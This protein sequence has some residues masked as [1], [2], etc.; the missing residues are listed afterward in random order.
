MLKEESFLG[1]Q[2]RFC[3]ASSTCTV[4]GLAGKASGKNKHFSVSH[5]SSKKIWCFCPSIPTLFTSHHAFGAFY[6]KVILSDAIIKY[7]FIDQKPMGPSRFWE[8]VEHAHLK[9]LPCLGSCRATVWHCF[10]GATGRKW[11]EMV[12]L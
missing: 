8:G 3:E 6:V 10:P 11:G 1:T 2:R 7:D 9:P 5:S 4:A 12:L